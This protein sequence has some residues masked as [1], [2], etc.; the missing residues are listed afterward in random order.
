M[1]LWLSLPSDDDEVAARA[2]E[3]AAAA[4]QA[5]AAAVATTTAATTPG[6][7]PATV[8][9]PVTVAEPKPAPRRATATVDFPRGVRV[10]MAAYDDM[11]EE[12]ATAASLAA[13]SAGSQ[14]GVSDAERAE[15]KGM[16]VSR[17]LSKVG[18]RL[19]VTPHHSHSKATH[20]ILIVHMQ[21]EAPLTTTTTAADATADDASATAPA[22]APAA[23]PITSFSLHVNLGYALAQ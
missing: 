10:A 20:F 9:P 2:A 4:A 12:G 21:P 23:Q 13:A 3:S 16:L 5:A 17:H 6:S 8:P 7:V 22:I 11:P 1:R 15:T 14:G 19:T 18:L